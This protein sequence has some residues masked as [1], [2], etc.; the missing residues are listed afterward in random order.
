MTGSNFTAY[1]MVPV[2]DVVAIENG[3]ITI[4]STGTSIIHLISPPGLRNI[5]KY[6]KQ[7]DN[8]IMDGKISTLV[9]LNSTKSGAYSNLTVGFNGSVSAGVSSQHNGLA[10]INISSNNHRGTTLSIFVTK[11]FLGASSSVYIKFNGQAINITSPGTILN[12]TSTTNA[13]YATINEST[14]VL[15]LIHVPH[16]SNHTLT[17]SSTPFTSTSTPQSSPSF[18]INTEDLSII[19]VIS[20]VA[21]VGGAALVLRRK[22]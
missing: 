5:G 10:L 7:I 11:Q 16:F 6:G 8:A 19:L 1:I 20:T 4:N 12:I 22:K 18:P 15:V 3:T 13:Y 2:N 21:I 14:G 17:V 9:F